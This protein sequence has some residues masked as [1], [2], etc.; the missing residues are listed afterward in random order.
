[1]ELSELKIEELHKIAL[2]ITKFIM[3]NEDA[4]RECGEND[5]ALKELYR[6]RIEEATEIRDKVVRIYVKKTLWEDVEK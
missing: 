2:I 5:T 4:E 6:T 1:M 3:E